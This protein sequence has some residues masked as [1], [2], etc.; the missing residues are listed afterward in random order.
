MRQLVSAVLGLA[1]AACGPGAGGA[2]EAA[3]QG[4]GEGAFV[5]N[6][7]ARYVAQNEQARQ[8]APEQCAQ[9]WGLVVA[10][11]P[12]AEAILAGANGTMPQAGRMNSNIDVEVDARA[13]TAVFSW[14]AVGELIPYDVVSALE[15]RGAA[16]SMIGCSQVGVGEFSSAYRVAPQGRT[17]FQLSIYRR[18]APTGNAWSFY[19]V[20]A[21]YSG[22]IQTRVQ[23]AS[24]GSEWTDACAY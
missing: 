18:E 11:G 14:S 24:D 10:A 12:M 2:N 6:C 20:T 13:R 22:R 21:D 4:G 19:T 17:P 9:E 7:V 16:P 23:L 1:L 5:E 15:Q 8:W 3:A